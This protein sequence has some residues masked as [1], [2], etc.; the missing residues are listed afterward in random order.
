M[1]A[2]LA[3]GLCNP[4]VPGSSPA[5]CLPLVGFVLGASVL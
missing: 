2:A 3:G 1:E 5:P 4:E